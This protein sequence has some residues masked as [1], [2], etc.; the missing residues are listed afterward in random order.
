MKRENDESV[1][2]A[3][4]DAESVT[5]GT[6][7]GENPPEIN[8]IVQNGVNRSTSSSVSSPTDEKKSSSSFILYNI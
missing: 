2:N 1:D 5:N 7:S 3:K 6:A 8:G 4:M